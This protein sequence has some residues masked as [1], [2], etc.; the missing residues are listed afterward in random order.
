[1]KAKQEAWEVGSKRSW[2]RVCVLHSLTKK[3][4]YVLQFN[5]KESA[6]LIIPFKYIMHKN[7]L[8]TPFFK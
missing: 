4:K 6:M 1:M 7:L 8:V 5:E 2:S 3:T